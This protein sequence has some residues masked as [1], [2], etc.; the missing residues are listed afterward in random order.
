[1]QLVRFGPT[2][3]EKPGI[4]DGQAILD[5]SGYIKD[6]NRE[7]FQTQ[8]PQYLQELLEDQ[9]SHLPRIPSYAAI[10][11]GAPVARPGN[12]VCIGLN[13][14]DHATEAGFDVPTLPTVFFKSPDTVIG[15]GDEVR[16]PPGSSKSD[17]EVELAVIIGHKAEHLPDPESARA[18]IAGYTIAN[19]LSERE[20]QLEHGGEWAKGKSAPTF[21]PLGPKLVTPDE[22]EDVQQLQMW[23]DV[24]GCRMQ[25]SSTANMLWGV[26][27]LLWHVSRYITLYPG[28]VLCTG[29][30]G[31]VGNLQKPPRY[32]KPGDVM[33]VGIHQLGTQH[34]TVVGSDG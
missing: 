19:E 28:D 14:A 20:W 8:G 32:L 3:H 1:M 31:G 30:P 29:T 25:N 4:L 2:G 16:L 23:L 24:N 21:C 12:V 5:V 9:R 11:L 17:W 27:W 18:C 15:P 6:Y 22:L 10:R 13:Y 33:D 26:E 7:F 34:L